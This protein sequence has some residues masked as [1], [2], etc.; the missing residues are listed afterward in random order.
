M[1]TLSTIRAANQVL[2]NLAPRLTARIARRMMMR[3]HQHQPRSWE[4]PALQAA[5]QITFRFGLAGL[6]WGGSGPVVLMMHGWQGRPTQFAA[7]VPALVASGRQ[8]IALEGPAHGRSPGDEAHVFAFAEALLEAAAELRGVESVIGHSMG[9]SAALC[10][11]EQGMRAER[12]VV[13]G[14]PAALRRV[15]HR[16]ATTIGLPEPAERAFHRVVD[17]HVGIPAEQLDIARF[18]SLRDLPGLV[19]HDRDDDSV[20]F[21]EGELLAQGWSAARFLATQGLGH[22]RVLGD[23]GV[24]AAITQFLTQQRAN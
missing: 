13:I 21:H 5:E 19:V 23:P 3:P 16:F 24:V 7:M 14:S 8:V 17:R 12:A 2:G 10:A 9:G 15:L 1:N 11:I 4:L 18:H 6:R 22:Q 20:P